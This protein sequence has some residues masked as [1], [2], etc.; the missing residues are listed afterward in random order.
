MSWPK[1]YFKLVAVI[2]L[3]SGLIG[4]AVPDQY[5]SLLGADGIVGGR[6]R[7]RAFGVAS[8]ISD[9]RPAVRLCGWVG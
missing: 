4:I 8:Q 9:L 7:G 3:A 2:L 6:L 1:T 5:I